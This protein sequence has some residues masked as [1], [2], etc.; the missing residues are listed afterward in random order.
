MLRFHKAA[1]A[2]VACSALVAA[3]LSGNS[4]ALAQHDGARHVTAAF[5]QLPQRMSTADAD[6]VIAA[7]KAQP[8]TTRSMANPLSSSTCYQYT[9]PD[10]VGDTS[11]GVDATNLTVGF[12]CKTG[13]WA[14]SF[15]VAAPVNLQALQF[16]LALD[17]NNDLTDNCYGVDYSVGVYWSSTTNAL[18]AG[19]ISEYWNG[20]SC[21][22]SY[23]SDA[24]ITF[25]GQTGKVV[26]SLPG[27]SI[28]NYFGITYPT[29]S[30]SP[31]QLDAVP[32][33]GSVRVQRT[34]SSAFTNDS[35]PPTINGVYKRGVAGDY[36]GDGYGD[37]YWYAPGTARDV[38]ALNPQF[39]SG[40]SAFTIM[41]GPVLSASYLLR[42]G[43]FD[44]DGYDDLFAFGPGATDDIIFYGSSTGAF[45]KVV[46]SPINGAYIPAVGDFNGDGYSD[47]LFYLPGT[48]SEYLWSGGVG[49]AF[50]KQQLPPI[51]GT[52][53]LVV[54]NYDGAN[55][56]DLFF[57]VPGTG[58][59]Y[60]WR[61]QTGGFGVFL[62][63]PKSINGTYAYQ[64]TGDFNCDGFDDLLLYNPNTASDALVRGQAAA[65]HLNTVVPTFINEPY[66]Q[67]IASKFT[68]DSCE[69]VLFYGT[70]TLPERFWS[71]K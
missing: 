8:P 66:S 38:L 12:N 1:A 37:V 31:S 6:A 57:Y 59:D 24:G 36:N 65:P 9:T 22:S 26:F 34:A 5:D 16:V 56:D 20:S 7:I 23:V 28:Q 14:A 64:S 13:G 21:D 15:T 51:N 68:T 44:N 4:P 32:N 47:I 54:G 48:G 29:N 67:V 41:T 45:T 71:G 19:L 39:A 70:G 10:P 30:T 18:E 53:K 2:L 33:G 50:T 27:V 62:K 3:N 49:R 43:D 61:G 60:L 46:L 52:Y 25:S 40:G 35:T 63:G 17:T 58:A 42:S 55:G 11:G 69:D